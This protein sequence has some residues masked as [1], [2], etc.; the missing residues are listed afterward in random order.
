M[1][2]YLHL[3]LPVLGLVF[4]VKPISYYVNRKYRI[5]SEICQKTLAKI[6]LRIFAANLLTRTYN[7]DIVCENLILQTVEAEITAMMPIQRACDAENQARNKLSN[8][9]LRAQSNVV[10]TEYSATPEAGV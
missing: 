6:F 8:G 2:A 9:P 3:F 4:I 5:L 10:T 1:N 7:G